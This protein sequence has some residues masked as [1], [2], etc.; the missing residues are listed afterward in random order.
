M[1]KQYD[2]NMHVFEYHTDVPEDR[3]HE[4][5][6]GVYAP[7]RFLTNKEC[8]RPKTECQ[9]VFE[10]C[11]PQAKVW[12]EESIYLSPSGKYYY[13]SAEGN[14]YEDES[15]RDEEY[16]GVWY[17]L[18]DDFTIDDLWVALRHCTDLIPNSAMA[19]RTAAQM[20]LD[21]AMNPE[22]PDK[23]IMLHHFL[24]DFVH[25][26]FY[27]NRENTT[28]KELY[29]AN[30]INF[31]KSKFKELC[32]VFMDKPVSVAE[33]FLFDDLVKSEV[34]QRVDS[35]LFNEVGGLNKLL[36][37]METYQGKKED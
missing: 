25:F 22:G 37:H 4:D 16:S 26:D 32:V 14:E 17:E 10:F 1:N 36:T 33:A 28:D 3:I 11:Y 34:G 20:H 27:F 23:G 8:R 31:T 6:Y 18:P 21:W 24:S 12:T 15:L 35:L 13:F 30:S 19:Y 9:R 7:L 2:F 5:I 29:R